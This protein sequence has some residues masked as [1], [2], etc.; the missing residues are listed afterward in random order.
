MHTA[1]ARFPAHRRLATGQ[2]SVTPF[3]QLKYRAAVI[4][5]KMLSLSRN[6]NAPD[7]QATGMP[8]PLQFNRIALALQ[9]L[10]N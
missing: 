1:C 10:A 2:Q 4:R 3:V 6:M 9:P 7:F 5:G 8:F